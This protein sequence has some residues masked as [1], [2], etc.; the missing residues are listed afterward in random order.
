MRTE[1]S[2]IAREESGLE[3]SG[4]DV[5]RDAGALDQSEGHGHE[6]KWTHPRENKEH[7]PTELDGKLD[8]EGTRRAGLV[9]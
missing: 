2:K 4:A 9:L 3:F 1:L 7:K 5:G 6:E 8:V